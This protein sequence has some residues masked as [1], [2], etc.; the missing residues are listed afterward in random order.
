MIEVQRGQIV[1][2]LIGDEDA[3]LT[4]FG[5]HNNGG[6]QARLETP[7]DFSPIRPGDFVRLERDRIL[8]IH[9]GHPDERD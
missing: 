3:W 4:V 2:A 8:G 9:T 1:H 6:I 7:L 5:D